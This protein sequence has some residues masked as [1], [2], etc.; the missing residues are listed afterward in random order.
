ML[1]WVLNYLIQFGSGVILFFQHWCET[2]NNP[3]KSPVQLIQQAAVQI[4]QQGQAVAVSLRCSLRKI[5]IFKRHNN[6]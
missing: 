5:I 6:F 3:F 2:W 1:G 4:P